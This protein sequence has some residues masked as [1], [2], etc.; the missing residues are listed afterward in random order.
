MNRAGSQTTQLANLFKALAHP[1]RV[2]IA[3]IIVSEHMVSIPAL[4]RQLPGVDPFMLYSN[5][6]YMHKQQVV[7]KLRKGREVYYALSEEA[8]V[9][10]LDTFFTGE[11]IS[12]T[13]LLRPRTAPLRSVKKK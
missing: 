6:R 9:A 11:A 3:T 5:L 12:P 10:R 4:Q 1:L 7:D 2:Q 8:I 13:P